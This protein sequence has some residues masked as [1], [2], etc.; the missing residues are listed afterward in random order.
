MTTPDQPRQLGQEVANRLR[1][2][3]ADIEAATPDPG[4][5]PDLPEVVA[6]LRSSAA[7]AE[8]APERS[9]RYIALRATHNVA[10]LGTP[11]HQ[12]YAGTDLGVYSTNANPNY[13][14]LAAEAQGDFGPTEG[15]DPG[16]TPARPSPRNGHPIEALG[17]VAD[18]MREAL[19]EQE[20][21]GYRAD[22]AVIEHTTRVLADRTAARQAH[23]EP[24]HEPDA[25][26]TLAAEWGHLQAESHVPWPHGRDPIDDEEAA[27][28]D[29]PTG[30]ND[31]N[32]TQ[33][34]LYRQMLE[35][36]SATG[37]DYWTT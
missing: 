10:R 8:N 4:A 9:A 5:V 37:T 19:A 20:A 31:L 22:M 28:M 33:N 30:L 3:A 18:A 15:L 7:A 11:F 17:D 23:D 35:Q 26:R 1:G 12:A 36:V 27:L 32:P 34:Q 13:A 16:P 24:S 6:K 21:R 25:V 14:G 2:L 29:A